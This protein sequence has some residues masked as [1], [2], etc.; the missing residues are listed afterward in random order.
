MSLQSPLPRMASRTAMYAIARPSARSL[1]TC[2]T[3]AMRTARSAVSV[4]QQAGRSMPLTRQQQQQ[5]RGYASEAKFDPDTVERAQ[6]E[7]DVC[8][9]GGGPAGLSA[10]IRLKQ[11]EQER[12]GEEIRVVVL[13]KGGEVGAHI[14]SGAVIETKAL[15]EL[16]PDWKELGAPLNQPA[17]SDSMRFL[18][19]KSS[20]PMPHPPQMNN[21]G[22]F[23]V[24]LSR[25]TAW[26]A[27]QAE[28][29]GVE[30]YPG[31]A[32][33]KVLYTEDGKG[34]KGVVTGD[35]GLDKDGQPKDSYEPGM[36]F[37]AKVT[38]IAEGAHGSLSKEV[39]KKFNLRDGVDPQTYGLGIKEVWKVRDEVYEPGKV[40]HT[41]GWPL[42]YKTYGGSWLYHM[43][44]NM[45]SMGLVVGLDYQNPYLSPYKEFQRMKHHPYFANILKDGQCIAY[46]ARALNEGGLQSIPKLNFPGGAL[47]GCSAGF[48]NVPKIKG[49]HNA[50]KSGMLAAES[51]F[52]AITAAPSAE[53]AT[54]AEGV[55]TDMSSYATAVEN[56]WI[57]KELKEVRNLRPSFHNPLG[58]WGGMAYSGLDSLILRGRVPW[59]FR[60]KVEDW[61]ATKKASEVKP[62]NY[63]QPDGKLSFDILTSVSMTG[64]N[65]AENQP[66]HLRLPEEAGAKERHTQTNVAEYAGL[67]GRVCPAAV[68][69]YAD[70]EGADVDAEGKKFVINSQNCIHCKTCSIKTPTQDIKW[71]VP[72]GGGGPKYTIT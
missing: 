11:L 51:A 58:L 43:E 5:Q 37:H 63:P 36:E 45:V 31:F 7:V 21:K 32:G 59:T 67:L 19:E 26:L 8:I 29:L 54:D 40:V 57:H 22:N 34:V 52:T 42:D 33:A 4:A 39:Q 9:V 28:A 41:L 70:A 30:V 16:I 23:I 47:L 27:E 48:L 3:S 17:T 44:D 2:S 50:M 60:N 61:E 25:F 56:S 65:H 69:E 18:T 62:I 24:S 64:T 55:P 14:L 38:L 71:T 72:E 15:D 66:V 10:A 20:F 12:G 1:A 53:D 68:Y 35:V 49:T 6:D 13:E 46:G